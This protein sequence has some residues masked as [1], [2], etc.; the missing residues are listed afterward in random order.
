MQKLRLTNALNINTNCTPRQNRPVCGGD[1]SLQELSASSK[2]SKQNQVNQDT[3]IAVAGIAANSTIAVKKYC[4]PKAQGKGVRTAPTEQWF[5]WYSEE[6]SFTAVDVKFLD[7]VSGNTLVVMRNNKGRTLSSG[8]LEQFVTVHPRSIQEATIEAF[9]GAQWGSSMIFDIM[10]S[11]PQDRV[12]RLKLVGTSSTDIDGI[13]AGTEQV[14]AITDMFV[15]PTQKDSKRIPWVVLST[16][17]VAVP[18]G[19]GSAQ[20]PSASRGTYRKSVCIALDLEAFMASFGKLREG[21]H[22]CRMDVFFETLRGSGYS[23]VVLRKSDSTG[24]LSSAD[25]MLV[26]T[27]KGYPLCVVHMGFLSAWSLAPE[28]EHGKHCFTTPDSFTAEGGIPLRDS[29]SDFQREMFVGS[30]GK[31][32]TM[33]SRGQVLAQNSHS[34]VLFND[35]EGSSSPSSAGGE[36]KVQIFTT[37]PKRTGSSR[38]ASQRTGTAMASLAACRP[39]AGCPCRP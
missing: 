5:V 19:Q 18:A 32:T 11:T 9:D 7:T 14:L 35:G 38:C 25:V 33:S 12:D 6:W 8:P 31:E 20:D 29:W 26:P 17:V 4:V 13:N 27:R 24:P 3:C 36:T 34:E 37:A 10:Y 30:T 23:T 16:V 22:V 1:S 15:L 2:K 28:E 21:A 39:R